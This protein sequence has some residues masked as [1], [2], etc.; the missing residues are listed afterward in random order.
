MKK[1]RFELRSKGSSK[2]KLKPTEVSILDFKTVSK[3]FQLNFETNSWFHKN[4]QILNFKLYG[5]WFGTHRKLLP[6][7]DE[8]G[9]AGEGNVDEDEWDGVWVWIARPEL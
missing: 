7:V 3:Y 5:K 4:T 9:I 8:V 1:P 2:S 6:F